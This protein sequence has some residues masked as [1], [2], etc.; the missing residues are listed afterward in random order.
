MTARLHPSRR[1]ETPAPPPAR[2]G[3][4]ALA[5]TTDLPPAVLALPAEHGTL[6]DGIAQVS[7]FAIPAAVGT[8]PTPLNDLARDLIGREPM[9]AARLT[10]LADLVRQSPAGR[11]ERIGMS[12]DFDS[13]RAARTAAHI[14]QRGTTAVTDAASAYRPLGS[15]AQRFIEGEYL[16]GS[17]HLLLGPV[18]STAVLDR[19]A[20]ND[21]AMTTRPG[22]VIA[23]EIAHARQPVDPGKL[24]EPGIRAIEEGRADVVARWSSLLSGVQSLTGLTINPALVDAD[25]TYGA[26][27]ASLIARLQAAGVHD[28]QSAVALLDSTEASVLAARLG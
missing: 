15:G 21:P 24:L 8:P 19:L 28:R 20:T 23:H 9:L 18:A 17:H 2:H 11:V 14:F 10:G 25:P 7:E 1:V 22:Y 5:A 12:A 27:R 26:E 16:P 4:S 6:G 3:S 13:F